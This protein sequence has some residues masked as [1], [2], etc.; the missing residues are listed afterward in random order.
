MRV[1][2]VKEYYDLQIKKTVTVGEVYDVSEARA[3]ELASTNNKAGAVL[4]EMLPD[5]SEKAA[6]GRKKKQEE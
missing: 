5:A 2:C 1:R 4:V 6:K 3:E